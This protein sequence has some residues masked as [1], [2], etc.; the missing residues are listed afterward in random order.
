M[1][2]MLLLRLLAAA[3]SC[4]CCCCCWLLLLAL[5]LLLLGCSTTYVSTTSGRGRNLCAEGRGRRA[6]RTRLN[7]RRLQ[8]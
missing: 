5:P 7:A 8:P 3:P 1:L 4:C 2:T 6:R